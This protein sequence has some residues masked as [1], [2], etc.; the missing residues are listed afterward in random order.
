M[1]MGLF[2]GA[3][4]VAFA[5]G[6]LVSTAAIDLARQWLGSPAIAYAVVFM[7]EGLLFAAAGWLAVGAP[8]ARAAATGA[9][10]DRQPPAG[11]PLVAGWRREIG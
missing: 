10:R 11:H 7:A 8:I 3:Q 6:G 9:A 5:A 2:G 1:R 4:A